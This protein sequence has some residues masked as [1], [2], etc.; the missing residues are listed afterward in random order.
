MEA[1]EFI[2]KHI[3]KIIGGVIIIFS[4]IISS[5]IY[6]N[7]LKVIG[8][9]KNQQDIEREK[10]ATLN[11]ISSLENK[12]VAYKRVFP[13]RDANSVMNAIS[14]IAKESFI[15]ILSIRPGQEKSSP[16]YAKFP[17]EIVVNAPD[18]HALGRF[19]SRIENYE[20]FYTVEIMDIRTDTQANQ[21]TVNLRVSSIAATD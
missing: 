13:R 15:K 7:Q 9:I 11:N 3:K 1:S 16:Y 5:N 14:N 4:I 21:L 18:Y 12:L 2:T 6:K 20:D 10:N 17:F 19:I 8:S